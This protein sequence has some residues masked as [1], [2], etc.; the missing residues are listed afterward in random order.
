[1]A[2]P[3]T[4][5]WT[6][7][8]YIVIGR[9]RGADDHGALAATA[10]GADGSCC[11]TVRAPKLLLTDAW[12]FWTG[13]QVLLIG[14]HYVGDTNRPLAE[15]PG[16]ATYDPAADAWEILP[17]PDL[18]AVQALAAAWT[19]TELVVWDYLL[20]AAAWRPGRGW[21]ELP[22]LPFRFAECYSEATAVDG[23]AF[24]FYCGDAAY[25]DPAADRWVQMWTP[26]WESLFPPGS[27]APAGREGSFEAYDIDMWCTYTTGAE[28]TLWSIDLDAVETIRVSPPATQSVWELVPHP[29]WSQRRD[30]SLVW[31]GTELMVWGGFDGVTEVF[32]GWAYQPDSGGMH[33]IPAA[34]LPGRPGQSGV[35][36]GDRFVVWRGP[37]SI[38]DPQSLSWTE[39]STANA[40]LLSPGTTALWT[41]QE[42]IFWG[43][44]DFYTSTERAAAFDG[45][46]RPVAPSPLDPR[47]H[48]VVVWSGD[49][50]QV[51]HDDAMY[52]WGGWVSDGNGGVAPAQDGAVYS[53]ATDTWRVLAPLP[54]AI[55]LAG[56]VGGWVDG[57]LI[58]F[59]ANPNAGPDGG[60][61][62]VL[63]AAYR[64]DTDTWRLIADLP[65]PTWPGEGLAGAMSAVVT[66]NRLAVWLPASYFGDEPG[67]GFYEPASDSWVRHPGSPVDAYAPELTWT[68]TQ[69]AALTEGGVLLLSP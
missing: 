34:P 67:F 12:A 47:S 64:P 28:P 46:W 29:E 33:R 7:S 18:E 8:E 30:A 3:L 17:A 55:H 15:R 14:G 25:F 23:K 43:A 61:P 19:G 69:V 37:L 56:P 11:R 57:E 31:T 35:W 48:S 22:D 27:C 38:W 5:A 36:A 49:G 60:E 52:V 62:D 6:G 1:M 10:Y 2:V 65:G 58:V 41:G 50:E 24:A 68:G 42:T 44:T 9:Q 21:R 39:G 51:E 20:Q 59:G 66:D 32:D 40:P 4:G 63:G 54:E 45:E 13:D 26:E 53:P 16:F